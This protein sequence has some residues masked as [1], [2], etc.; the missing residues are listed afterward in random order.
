MAY[1]FLDNTGLA[2]LFGKIK[3]LLNGKSDT[4]HTHLYAGSSTAGGVATSASKLSTART[5]SLSGDA[6]GS[7]SFDGSANKSITVT[8]ANS[9]VTAG[10]YGLSADATPAYGASFN[11]P[12]ITVDAKGRVT[13]AT[14]NTVKI[15]ASDKVTVDTAM[16]STSTNPVQNKVV[17]T[18]LSAKAPLASPALTGTPTAPTATAGTNTTQ[19]ATTAFVKTAVD[20]KTSIT[21]NAATATKA[22]QDGNGNEITSTYETKANAITGLSVS[23][24]V[25]TYT[26]G[27]GATGTITTQDTNTTYTQ[28]KL[29]QGYG[30]C[31]TA[32]ATVA[33][34]V[35]LSN[36]TLTKGG[37]V[38]VKFTYAVPAEATMNI[39]S[40]GA[41]N[42]F[43]K[44]I[45][46]APE[47]QEQ[48]AKM[49]KK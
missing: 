11:V 21:G 39:N 19:I 40:K 9:G 30:T 27:D 18:A 3:T 10:S 35:T 6:S 48:T 33:K 4:D 42:I 20:N 32:Q 34:A 22:S 15:P 38:S 31:A 12:Y 37:I 17:N 23:G 44:Y 16:S 41:K 46:K 8:L 49:S 13:G 25:I 14:T 5:I 24:K 1:K 43:Y 36:Y 29:G 7:N 45:A 26:K 2:H 47:S 28:E